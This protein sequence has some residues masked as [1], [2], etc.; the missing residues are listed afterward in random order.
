[1]GNLIWNELVWKRILPPASLKDTKVSKAYTAAF[2]F[3]LLVPFSEAAS[4]WLNRTGLEEGLPPAASSAFAKGYG[5]TGDRA[6]EFD[7]H[8][9]FSSL[10]CRC[11]EEATACGRS[12]QDPLALN[13]FRRRREIRRG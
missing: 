1:L 6:V 4:E 10:L 13:C 11:G 9:L 7:L 3:V 5:A 2:F 12:R 8:Q